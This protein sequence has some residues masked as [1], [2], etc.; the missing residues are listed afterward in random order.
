MRHIKYKKIDHVSA[1]EYQT[2]GAVGFDL[3]CAK[4]I[5]VPGRSMVRVST[6]LV[7]EVPEGIALIL[8]PRSSTF[9]KYGLIMPHS[10]GVIDQDYSGNDDEV[11]LQMYNVG[12][13]NVFVPQGTRIAQ[14]LFIPVERATFVEQAS[15]LAESRGGFGSTG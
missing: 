3:E 6:G 8:A 2:P 13:A 7:I 11:L 9:S 4:D 14:G 5:N 12:P 10:I 15:A 1:P